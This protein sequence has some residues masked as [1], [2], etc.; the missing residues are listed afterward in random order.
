M[1]KWKLKVENDFGQARLTV[2]A[3]GKPA[4]LMK[5]PMGDFIAIW[6]DVVIKIREEA[7]KT[8]AETLTRRLYIDALALFDDSPELAKQKLLEF[9]WSIAK[10][11]Q[12]AKELA[13]EV[14]KSI[15]DKMPG[16]PD[17]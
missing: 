3:D 9:G 7:Q 2:T 10:I 6:R 15:A 11:D 17:E 12:Y 13:I 14:A 16:G 1:T 4:G 5:M 8:I